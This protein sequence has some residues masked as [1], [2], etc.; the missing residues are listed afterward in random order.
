LQ[1]GPA[2][3]RLKI[4]QRFIRAISEKGISSAEILVMNSAGLDLG[5][6]Y[7]LASA[8]DSDYRIKDVSKVISLCLL[9]FS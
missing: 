6:P 5:F 2:Q 1:T 7:Q 8:I 9:P 4:Q 3:H